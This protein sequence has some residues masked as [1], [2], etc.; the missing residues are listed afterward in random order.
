MGTGRD[1]NPNKQ[2]DPPSFYILSLT[3]TLSHSPRTSECQDVIHRGIESQNVLTN[4]KVELRRWRNRKGRAEIRSQ[5]LEEPAGTLSTHDVREDKERVT[6]QAPGLIPGE[7]KYSGWRVQCLCPA[8]RGPEILRDHGCE[9][10]NHISVL[11]TVFPQGWQSCHAVNKMLKTI[12]QLLP[13]YS[14]RKGFA[15]WR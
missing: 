10:P 13:T 4:M 1:R 9:L 15:L 3:L 14:I 2:A 12:I 11:G 8:V 5:G 6:A 7:G